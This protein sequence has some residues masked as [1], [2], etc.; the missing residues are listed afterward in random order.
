MEQFSRE[1]NLPIHS[2]AGGGQTTNAFKEFLRDPDSLK[3][4][5]VVVW[6][7]CYADMECLPWPLPRPIR[8]A[9]GSQ[10]RD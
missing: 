1:L 10:V 8:D 6:I 5:K 2:L 3:G 4:C 7:V 9:V